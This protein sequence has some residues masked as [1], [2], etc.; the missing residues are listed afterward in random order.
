MLSLKGCGLAVH[1][2]VIDWYRQVLPTQPFISGYKQLW[3]QRQC[4]R[5]LTPITNFSQTPKLRKREHFPPIS[6]LFFFFGALNRILRHFISGVY[7]EINTYEMSVYEILGV[8]DNHILFHVFR[9]VTLRRLV[10]RRKIIVKM[11]YDPSIRRYLFNS[12][13]GV[14][15]LTAWISR[16]SFVR[17]LYFRDRVT[18]LCSLLGLSCGTE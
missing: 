8:Y 13:H 4:S 12:R 11:H 10:N 2:R 6:H 16:F 7:L 18:N 17:R 14:T 15:A 1:G 5:R 3:I 9:D